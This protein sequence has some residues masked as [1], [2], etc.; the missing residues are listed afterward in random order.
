MVH[1]FSS[2]SRKYILILISLVFFFLYFFLHGK[3]ARVDALSGTTTHII[4]NQPDE[5]A[6]YF[7]IKELVLNH[8]FGALEP[9]NDIGLN[10]V[11]PRSMTVINGR[12]APIGFP[13]FIILVAA[14]SYIPTSVLGSQFFNLFAISLVPILAILSNFLLYGIVKRLWNERMAVFSFVLLYLVPPWWYWASRPFQHVIPFV[15]FLLLA[16]YGILRMKDSEESKTKICFSII[17]ALGISLA[18]ALRPNELV[19]VLGLY[20]YLVYRIRSTVSKQQIGV[21][22]GTVILVALLFFITQS[23]FYGSIFASGYVRPLS[24]G[25]GGNVLAGGQGISFIRAF[26]FPFGIHF[27]TAVKTAYH[28]F[29]QLFNPL[30]I[31]TFISCIFIIAR[32]EKAIRTYLFFWSLMSVY[33]ILSYGSWNFTDN[34]LGL[35]S[36]GGSQIRYFM[37]VYV[38]AIPLIAYFLDRLM[39]MFQNKKYI[40]IYIGLGILFLFSSYHAVYTS[41]PEG[42]TRVKN[43]LGEYKKWQDEVYS[44]ADEGK[45]IITRYSDKYLF[46][47][48]KVIIRTREEPVWAEATMKLY[49]DITFDFYWYDLKLSSEEKEEVDRTLD[50]RGLKLGKVEASWGDLELRSIVEKSIEIE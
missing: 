5:M 2:K 34:L 41:F 35:P 50:V 36:I 30:A 4:S 19:W 22:I 38:G 6:N 18:L 13:F 46:P 24:T 31:W 21:W 44:I 26:I 32:G 27:M 20:G 33:L 9:L 45:I 3:E 23:A 28:Y 48:R 15:F 43:T 16:V 25:E 39:L 47:G 14:F 1:I 12:L 49:F 42:L 11:H 37:P 10:Q 7:F 17:S 40:F 29:F 8:S